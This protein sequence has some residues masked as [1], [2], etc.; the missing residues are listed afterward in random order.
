MMRS[1]AASRRWL[2][3]SPGCQAMHRSAVSRGQ[4][5][6]C[7]SSGEHE[8]N[9][10][11]APDRASHP[12]KTG[13]ACIEPPGSE[14]VRHWVGGHGRWQRGGRRTPSQPHGPR[15]LRATGNHIAG[16]RSRATSDMHSW[17]RRAVSLAEADRTLYGRNRASDWSA[18]GGRARM[19]DCSSDGLR[20]TT[21][22]RD[23][24]SCRLVG[25]FGRRPYRGD[26]ASF[27]RLAD[28]PW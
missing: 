19:P 21:W 9:L 13:D 8:A 15:K 23:E 1:W 4:R 25:G 12:G 10:K 6:G 27:G 14:H 16:R 2:H 24:A 11:K 17:P 7:N 18:V 28:R 20:W 26:P 5:G 3:G 22:E